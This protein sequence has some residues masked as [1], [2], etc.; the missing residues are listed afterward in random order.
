MGDRHT[1]WLLWAVLGI[2]AALRL[3]QY[4]AFSFS[5]DELSALSRLGYDSIRE[6]VLGGVRPDGHPAAAQVVLWYVTRWFGDREAVVRLPFVLAGIGA[7]WYTFRMGRAWASISAGLL[8]AAA[9]ASLE[10]PL[11]YSRIARPYA[12]GMLFSTVTVYHWV[13][14]MRGSHR[15]RDLM[16][17]AVSLALCAYTHY[18]CGLTAA[19]MA[20]IGTFTLK[21]DALRGYLYALGGAVVLFLPHLPVTLHQLGMG[22]VPWVGIPQHD[23]PLEHLHHVM[24]GSWAV[25]GTLAAVGIA[26]WFFFR[27]K[28]NWGQWLLPLLLFA[29]PLLVGFFYSRHVSPVLQ[30]SV[31]LF[32]F[33]FLLMFLFSGWDDSRPWLTSAAV[34]VVLGAGILSTIFQKDFFGKEHFGVFKELADRAVEWHG[35]HG[36]GLLLVAD[37]NHPSY[38]DRYTDRTEGR[39]LRFHL[40][41][42]SE[43]DGLIRL[44]ELMAESDAEHLAYAWSTVNQPPEVERIIREVYPVEVESETHF[45]SGVRLFRRGV[46]MHRVISAFGF[47]N[48]DGWQCD[49]DRVESDSLGMQWFV[50]NSEH[51][52]GPAFSA[53]VDS[54]GDG[55]T[56][57]VEAA[58]P[59]TVAEFLIVFEQWS[60]DERHVWEARPVHAQIRQGGTNWAVADFIIS[61]EKKEGDVLKVYGWTV[62]GA[63]V[64]VLRM[65]VR[66]R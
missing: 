26:G 49:P 33:P 43:G 44:K 66:E 13:R 46:P 57:F 4:H 37:V 15:T 2:G 39:G 12:L 22:G 8:V 40:Y 52:Y 20:L 30:H 32:S 51:P 1:R 3:W 59:D 11:L 17:L 42:V 48:A 19:I 36:E 64:R 29:V 18:F 25:F 34:T 21:G 56:V 16:M 7:V 23:W 28:R 54:V 53:P 31:L 6:L 50:L 41:R 63:T 61:P 45:N 10:F 27:P 14:V 55:V 47:E 24:N 62:H 5:N 38:L 9:M 65:E 60:G 58:L 35:Q